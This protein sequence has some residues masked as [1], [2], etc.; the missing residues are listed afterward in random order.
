MGVGAA[1]TGDSSGLTA[2][3]AT[4]ANPSN[5]DGLAL[6]LGD[7]GLLVGAGDSSPGSGGP[8]DSTMPSNNDPGGAMG[9]GAALSGVETV[10]APLKRALCARC[11]VLIE[12][13]AGA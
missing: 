12:A 1:A 3:P 13:G 2:L 4:S 11:G 6:A 9:A 5:S 7:G 10:A 8:G